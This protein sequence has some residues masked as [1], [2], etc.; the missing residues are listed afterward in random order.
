MAPPS[1]FPAMSQSRIRNFSIV[2]HIDHGK[3]T[4]ADRLIEATNTVEKRLMRE[5][6]L[7]MAPRAGWWIP[8]QA[9]SFLA[10]TAVSFPAM[11]VIGRAV[12]WDFPSAP[13]WG[14]MGIVAGLIYGAISGA[15]LIRLLRQPG[16]EPTAGSARQAA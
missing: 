3:S 4:L 8:A 5:Q 10:A 7:D 2:A 1:I 11:M 14:L 12:G 15:L 16:S 6:L 13:A 9:L